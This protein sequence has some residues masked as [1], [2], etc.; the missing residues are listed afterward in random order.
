MEKYFIEVID[1]TNS[2]FERIRKMY[3]LIAP[4]IL[5]NAHRKRITL[6]LNARELYHI[7]RLRQDA[8][9]QWDI[10]AVSKDMAAEANRVMPLAFRMAKGKDAYNDLYREMFGVSPKVTEAVLPASRKIH[11][12]THEE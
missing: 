7:C 12:S 1:K 4:Y 10:R 6:R 8:H 2:T 3:P 9:A 5:T 11:C